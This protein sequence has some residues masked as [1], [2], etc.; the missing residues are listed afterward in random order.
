MDEQSKSFIHHKNGW[1]DR[2]SPEVIK[3]AARNKNIN[4]ENIMRL[5]LDGK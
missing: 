4:G 1:I 3:Q 2:V 5:F